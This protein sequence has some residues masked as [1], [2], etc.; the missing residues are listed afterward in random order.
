[1]ICSNCQ[2]EIAKDS[3]YCKYCGAQVLL[4]SDFDPQ[5]KKSVPANPRKKCFALLSAISAVFIVCVSLFVFF[6]FFH[7]SY[8]YNAI[9]I[10]RYLYSQPV[11][12]MD[13]VT[14]AGT[15][16]NSTYG[17]MN[18]TTWID[19]GGT[20]GNN[21]YNRL[22][23]F[24]SNRQAR[25]YCSN[26]N[27]NFQTF[28]YGNIVLELSSDMNNESLSAYSDSMEK[29]S[30]LTEDDIKRKEIRPTSVLFN[31]FIDS[32][33]KTVKTTG[34]YEFEE[35]STDETPSDGIYEN[36]Y[37]LNPKIDYP[38]A[39]LN[40]CFD[41]NGKVTEVCLNSQDAKLEKADGSIE[42][43][44]NIYYPVAV[45]CALLSLD[46]TIDWEKISDNL[47]KEDYE[48]VVND[49]FL[50]N[51]HSEEYNYYLTTITQK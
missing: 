11:N 44:E 46:P 27:N 40:I 21:T 3:E 49:Y 10:A 12:N 28:R 30:D 13:D 4:Y 35:I 45:S 14:D 51:T 39:L 22:T 16:N 15:T 8:K 47:H 18:I 36:V 6:F 17:K 5:Q 7:K 23:A 42:T 26:S 33:K 34:L 9:D 48:V 50:E 2:K 38:Y 43:S 41:K 20:H 24:A 32:F 1:M 29:L 31:D 37:K 19:T 25:R